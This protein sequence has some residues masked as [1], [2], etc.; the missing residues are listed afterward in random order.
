MYSVNIMSL[1]K[2]DLLKVLTG[3]GIF[4]PTMVRVT[5]QVGLLVC[6]RY[7]GSMVGRLLVRLGRTGIGTMVW[8]A[9]K[10]SNEY[11]VR[12]PQSS[13]DFSKSVLSPQWEWNYQPRDEMWSLTER[14][15][16]LRLKAFR[17][18]VTDNLL[19]AGNTLTQRCF[20]TNKNEVI[21]KMNIEGMV[22][23]QKAGLCHYSKSYAMV[24]VRQS[25]K[26]RNLEFQTNKEKI[27]GPAIKGNKVWIKS[28]WGLDGKSQFSYST[29]GRKFTRSERYI[30]LNGDITGEAALGFTVLII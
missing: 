7:I 11:P 23:G 5:G 27:T 20:C 25:G 24:G 26:D 22:D 17:P 13:D 8:Q 28:V 10:P 14:P 1:I 2:A 15:G 9:A 6:Y 30:N 21:V 29:D 12:T 4:L 16:N 19:K 3:S 18:L